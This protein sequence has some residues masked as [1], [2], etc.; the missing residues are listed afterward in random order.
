MSIENHVSLIGNLGNDPE[1]RYTQGG[2]AVTKFSLAT[3]SSRKD[4]EGNRVE[5][6][7]WHR[8]VCFGKLAEIAGE[9]LRK[10]SKVTVQGTIRYGKYD[11]KD[12]VTR[13]TTDIVFDQMKMLDPPRQTGERS[14]RP[15]P[16]Q[17]PAA[18]HGSSEFTD[19]DIPF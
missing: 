18:E 11:D 19:D 2:T 5:S 4:R 15:E 12:G 7:E 9:Y 1:T 13:Y 6:T 8:C 16:R 3:T 10:G 17:R 14:E